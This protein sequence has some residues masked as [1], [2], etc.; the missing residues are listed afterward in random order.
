MNSACPSTKSDL[1]HQLLTT[2]LTRLR[3][4]NIFTNGQVREDRLAPQTASHVRIDLVLRNT[5]EQHFEVHL[6]I[7]LLYAGFKVSFLAPDRLEELIFRL[8]KQRFPNVQVNERSSS[9]EELLLALPE[10][11]VF[12]GDESYELHVQRI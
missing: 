2:N 5:S 1:V 11:S 8:L 7:D 10:D 3:C 12:L 6:P 9:L 4:T